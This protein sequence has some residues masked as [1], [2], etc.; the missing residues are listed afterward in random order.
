MKKFMLLHYGLEKPT[1]ELMEKWNAWFASVAD[2]SVE[3]GGLMNGREITGD[4]ANSL[5]MDLS[6]ITGYSVINAESLEEAESIAAENPFI[7]S[8]RVYEV[9]NHG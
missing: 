6:A 1:P 5:P 2:R 4:G 8:I 3:H 9:L 7:T